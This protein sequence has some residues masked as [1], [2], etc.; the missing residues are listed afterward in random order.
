MKQLHREE[1]A[2]L[3]RPMKEAAAVS[4]QGML[5][6]HMVR[7]ELCST[8]VR[9]VEGSTHGEHLVLHMWV[10]VRAHVAQVSDRPARQ[11]PLSTMPSLASAWP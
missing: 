2:V 6:G 10:Q 4:L 5:R 3:Q 7:H 11:H 8:D 1:L 9:A